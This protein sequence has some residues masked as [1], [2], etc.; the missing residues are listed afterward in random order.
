MRAM[1]PPRLVPA[2][3]HTK[4]L[5]PGA[6][7]SAPIFNAR[8]ARSWPM[9]PSRSSACA[10]VSN[11]MRESSH[12]QRSLAAGSSVCFGAGLVVM[13]T[14]RARYSSTPGQRSHH[15]TS[16][17]LPSRH[18]RTFRP[19]HVDRQDACGRGHQNRTQHQTEHS[20][21]RDA[22]HYADENDQPAQF[23]PAAEQD[24]AQDIVHDG[25]NT[26]AN[27]EQKKG[28]PPMSGESQPQRRR[29][30]DQT[31]ANH[32]HEGEKRHRNAPEQRRRQAH[33]HKAQPAEHAL[34]HGNNQ[35]GG[36]ARGDEVARLHDHHIAM[37][38]V[39]GK[40][41]ADSA[42]NIVGVAKEIE[43]RKNHNEKI[44]NE[45]GDV[46]KDGAEALR[47][48]ASLLLYGLLKQ[49]H[50]VG[51]GIEPRDALRNPRP[52]FRNRRRMILHEG[53]M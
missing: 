19:L 30:E 9:K 34:N 8:S 5:Y 46:P 3:P 13:R 17:L 40:D 11:G 12:L 28:A 2:N 10:V 33:Q 24:G 48:I 14:L 7:S 21:D 32:W 29:N 36:D 50:E 51:V 39:E 16:R 44:E 42:D 4:T 20:E 38:R 1:V 25:G 6:E 26:R 27:H 49:I 31:G 15:K 18:R 35:A 52:G 41:A 53:R 23:G 22:T 37:F 43:E 45:C 47:E